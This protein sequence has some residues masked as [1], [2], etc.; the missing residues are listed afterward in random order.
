MLPAALVASAFAIVGEFLENLDSRFE[1]G[2][3][4]RK[5]GAN[6][7]RGRFYHD[8]CKKHREPGSDQRNRLTELLLIIGIYTEETSGKEVSWTVHQ[9]KRGMFGFVVF[10][11]LAGIF[12]LGP[13]VQM[14]PFLTC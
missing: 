2:I 3:Y 6:N 14:F 5:S 1:S 12:G 10:G 7:F 4:S 9:T 11:L 13:A 8:V